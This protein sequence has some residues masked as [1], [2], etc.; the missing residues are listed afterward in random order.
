MN[1]TRIARRHVASFV[2][3][4]IYAVLHFSRTNSRKLKFS[5]RLPPP[6][7]VD[8][9]GRR[10]KTLPSSVKVFLSLVSVRSRTANSVSRS[11]AQR[12]ARFFISTVA[13]GGRFGITVELRLLGPRVSA[14]FGSCPLYRSYCQTVILLRERCIF[15]IRTMLYERPGYLT[16]LTSR[17]SKQMRFHRER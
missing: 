10:M 2:L 13:R 11:R 5:G 6:L 17:V 4:V 7:R 14:N 3:R 9:S 16:I 15:S 8:S 1:R 12:L